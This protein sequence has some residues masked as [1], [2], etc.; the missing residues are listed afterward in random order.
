MPK[1]QRAQTRHEVHADAVRAKFGRLTPFR[2]GFSAGLN[3]E[4]HLPSPYSSEQAS[5]NYTDGV[6]CG[7]RERTLVAIA[8]ATGAV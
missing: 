2:L 7:T 6:E 3:G 5:R 4:K 1:P 8:R